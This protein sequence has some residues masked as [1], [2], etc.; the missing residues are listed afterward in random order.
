M[1]G[2][3]CHSVYLMCGNIFLY[4]ILAFRNVTWHIQQSVWFCAFPR[5]F[6]LSTFSRCNQLYLF[7]LPF[8]ETMWGFLY[9]DGVIIFGGYSFRKW[10]CFEDLYFMNCHILSLIFTQ[11]TPLSDLDHQYLPLLLLLCLLLLLSFW[12]CIERFL[13]NRIVV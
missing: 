7:L 5:N 6:Y 1:L 3:R 10:W 13:G 8:L 12:T 11:C 2:C 4:L 9:W